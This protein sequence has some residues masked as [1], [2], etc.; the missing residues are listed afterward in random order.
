MVLGGLAADV[1]GGGDLWIGPAVGDQ[2]QHLAFASTECIERAGR[3]TPALGVAPEQLAGP[4]GL[5]PA[6]EL[7]QLSS[8]TVE[9]VGAASRDGLSAGDEQLGGLI[10]AGDPGSALEP[11]SEVGDDGEG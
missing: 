1:E 10:G 6:S 5:V 11:V 8:D 2:V 7:G 3:L 9:V 4:L